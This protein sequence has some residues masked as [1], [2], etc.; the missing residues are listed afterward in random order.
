MKREPFIIIIMGFFLTTSEE[1]E[2]TKSIHTMCYEEMDFALFDIIHYA[3]Q[4]QFLSVPE[5]CAF[6]CLNYSPL[7]FTPGGTFCFSVTF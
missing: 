6:R 5:I 4:E 3:F 7:T 2:E 1:L